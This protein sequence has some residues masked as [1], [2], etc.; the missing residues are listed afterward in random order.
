MQ[1]YP[2]LTINFIP[3]TALKRFW[4]FFYKSLL[5]KNASNLI[6]SNGAIHR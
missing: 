6:R 1:L 2:N 5:K 3:L 4:T